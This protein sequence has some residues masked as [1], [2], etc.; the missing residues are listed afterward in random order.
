MHQMSYDKQGL[1]KLEELNYSRLSV[2]LRMF[3]TFRYGRVISDKLLRKIISLEN[4]IFYSHTV[5]QVLSQKYNITLGSYSY[6]R[7]D[8]LYQFPIKTIIGRYTSIGSGVR[9]YQANHPTNFVS[10]HPFFYRTKIGI[11]EKEAI[12]R[13]ELDIGHDVWIGANAIICPSC[14][15]VGNGAVIGAGAV[16]TK[17]VPDYA[18]VGG[19]PAKVIR[20]RFGE[21]T[22]TK[23]QTIRWWTLPIGMIKRCYQEMTQP[24]DDR[25]LEDLLNKLD[26]LK[27]E[28][29]NRI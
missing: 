24:L 4:G 17:N 13:Y 8:D 16:V 28:V 23:L 11:V 9:V 20:M 5:R 7:L 19:N 3:D 18:I 25:N 12:Q 27:T 1:Y 10:M 26:L 14:H 2:L 15:K 21:S 22:I 6:G 29:N